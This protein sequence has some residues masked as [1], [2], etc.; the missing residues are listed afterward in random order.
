MCDLRAFDIIYVPLKTR[1]FIQET[2][3]GLSF[4][5]MYF[6]FILKFSTGSE[7]DKNLVVWKS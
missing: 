4:H 2:I 6:P 7:N 1:K 3:G 5:F